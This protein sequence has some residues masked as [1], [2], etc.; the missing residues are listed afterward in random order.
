MK[1]IVSLLFILCFALNLSAQKRIDGVEFLIDRDTAISVLK[2]KFGDPQSIMS[3][4]IIFRNIAFDGEQFNEAIFF[5]DNKGR[6]Y[7]VRLKSDYA[8][9]AK[10]EDRMSKLGSKYSCIYKITE[11]ENPDDGKFIVGYDINGGRLFTISTFRNTC[12]LTFGPF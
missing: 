7:Q 5:F 1:K 4:R 8:N 9:H 3:D 10:A 6:M 12:D 11:S 2:G